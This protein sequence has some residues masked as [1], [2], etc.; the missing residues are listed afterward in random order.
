MSGVSFILINLLRFPM[1]PLASL[2]NIRI[3]LGLLILLNRKF[4]R[5]RQTLREI[6]NFHFEVCLNYF[7][8]T[9]YFGG[10]A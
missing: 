5:D 7:R 3:S 8:M 4:E 6:L 2:K 9:C 10:L 1:I